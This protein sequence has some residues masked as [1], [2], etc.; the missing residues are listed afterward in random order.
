MPRKP[1]SSAVEREGVNFARSIVE[2]ANCIFQEIER[3]NDFGNDAIIELV[4]GEDVRG[5]CLAA[6]IKSG[7][8]YCTEI[9]CIIPASKCHFEYWHKHTLPVI[10][11]VYDP[12]EK[13][14]YWSSITGLLKHDPQRVTKGPFTIRFAKNEISRFNQEGFQLFFLPQFLKNT[15]RLP[16]DRSIMFINSESTTMQ[17]IGLQSLFYGYRNNAET[18]DFLISILKNKNQADINPYL[19]YLLSLIPGHGD[20]FWHSENIIADTIRREIRERIAN[21]EKNEVEKLIGFVGDDGIQ[22]GALGQCVEAI[23]S[24]VHEN[25][26][27]LREITEDESAEYQ[28]RSVALILLVYYS[29]KE[30]ERLLKTLKNLNG[31]LACLVN[32]LLEQVRT[33]GFVYLY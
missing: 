10:G 1:I 24:L 4:E 11:I 30:A 19:V 17:H 32:D 26:R 14:A 23:I 16:H 9:D 28:V 27:I 22:R 31:E 2:A 12:S 5:I 3:R 7:A 33:Y 20:I 21:F 15:I 29:G 25:M 8:S 13:C 18:W 6:Q